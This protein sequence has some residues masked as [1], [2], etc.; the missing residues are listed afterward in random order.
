LLNFNINQENNSSDNLN[1]AQDDIRIETEGSISAAV[2][3]ST[4]P[5]ANLIV[6]KYETEKKTMIN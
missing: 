1:S 5:S 4:Y 3:F 6:P 2:I